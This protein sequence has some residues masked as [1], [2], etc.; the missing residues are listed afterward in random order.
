MD[1]FTISTGIAGFLSL[2]LEIIKVLNDYASGVSSAT[3]EANNLLAEANALK[4]VL[5]Q[6]VEFLRSEEAQQVSF[7]KNAV[8]YSTI[9]LS[10]KIEGLYKKLRGLCTP[11][12]GGFGHIVERVQWPLKKDE[13]QQ[14][15]EE[16]RR[17]TTTL[18]FSCAVKNW[19]NPFIMINL[20]QFTN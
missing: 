12:N 1:P 16:L 7:D 18:Q 19:F 11:K 15:A 13:C 4:P 9:T 10:G 20:A 17:F 2:T 6:L 8:L 14:I 3:K 5:E